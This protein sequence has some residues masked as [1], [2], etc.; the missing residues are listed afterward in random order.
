MN[1]LLRRALSASMSRRIVLMSMC[2]RYAIRVV[3]AWL[4]SSM[5]RKCKLHSSY[6]RWMSAYSVNHLIR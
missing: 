2:V 1:F 6:K 4:D 5:R 3:G